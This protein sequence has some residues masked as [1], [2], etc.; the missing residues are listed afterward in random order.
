MPKA[1]YHGRH[2][3]VELPTLGIDYAK[4]IN[5]AIKGE[6]GQTENVSVEVTDAQGQI[7]ANLREDT[8]DGHIYAWTVE[9]IAP[10]PDPG[11]TTEP[12][13]PVAPVETAPIQTAPVQTLPAD[14]PTPDKDTTA[15]TTTT[16]ETGK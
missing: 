13:V 1:T 5:A 9:G 16:E 15:T 11:P 12:V 10:T 3:D 8:P 2:L 4:N 6:D 7:L 14:A